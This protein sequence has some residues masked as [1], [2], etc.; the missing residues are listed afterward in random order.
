MSSIISREELR[1]LPFVQQP[2]YPDS[3]ALDRTIDALEKL[4]PLVFAG[5]CDDLREKIATN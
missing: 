4:P 5:E 1:A 3:A 2:T